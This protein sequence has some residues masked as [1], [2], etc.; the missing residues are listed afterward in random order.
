MEANVLIG[1]QAKLTRQP[2]GHKHVWKV[3]LRPMNRLSL[4]KFVKKVVFHLHRSYVNPKRVI[5]EAPYELKETGDVGFDMKIV[6]YFKTSNMPKSVSFTYG[7]SL[8]TNGFP[9]AY[10]ST[11]RLVFEN[12]DDRLRRRLFEAGAELKEHA[13]HILKRLP[14]EASDRRHENVFQPSVTLI[15]SPTNS[16]LLMKENKPRSFCH[17][18]AVR[19]KR[20]SH[21]E[22]APE[23]IRPPGYLAHYKRK[24][25]Q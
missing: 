25:P 13:N 6:V 22:E 21:T 8:T 7:L 19:K 11:K 17:S 24:R 4:E 5:R 16:E 10:L 3:Y 18:H 20:V 12:P 14:I 15:K 9:V 23:D 2:G 1:H